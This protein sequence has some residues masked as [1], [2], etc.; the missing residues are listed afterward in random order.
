MYLLCAIVGT[1]EPH[2][3]SKQHTIVE[4]L[5]MWSISMVGP[6]HVVII[7]SFNLLSVC[8]GTNENTTKSPICQ[9]VTCLV[10]LLGTFCLTST[11]WYLINTSS[12]FSPSI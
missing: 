10:L 8:F 1:I 3:I 6:V 9:C 12:S 5:L 2:S 11:I 7:G 4:S